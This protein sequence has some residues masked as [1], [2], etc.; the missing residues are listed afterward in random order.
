MVKVEDIF[1]DVQAATLRVNG[2][3]TSENKFVKLGA[4]HTMDLELHRPFTITKL[5]WDII[6]MDRIQLACDVSKRADIAA[7]VLQEGLA[8]VCLVTESMTV[9]KQK[10]EVNVP[11]KRRGTTTDHDK[12]LNRF[13][14]QILQSILTYIDFE[15]VKV[16][17]IASP[18]F[19][20]DGLYKYIMEVAVKT[21]NRT[22]FDHKS[23]IVLAHASSGHKHALGE[24]L[25]DPGIQQQLATTKY[26]QEVQSLA[27][28]YKI[29]GEDPCKAFYGYDY[30][31]KAAEQGAIH[32]LMMTDD[33]FR[34]HDVKERK[35]YIQL[36]E[37]VKSFGGQ[38]L[39]FSS[40]HTSGEQLVQLT[41]IAAILNFPMPDLEEQVELELEKKKHLALGGLAP[42]PEDDLIESD[43]DMD[44]L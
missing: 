12:G 24:I 41:G 34:S 14:D 40:L 42:R 20:K 37:L 35:K 36:V 44:A 25:Q 26:A 6:S 39:I 15:I 21:E 43:H 2:R 22:L 38:A 1:F 4:Y 27:Q 3:N 23:K 30:V 17:I 29:L 7:V 16:L 18:G 28:F 33:L 31:I 5:E 9:V 10:I 13:Y 32:T 8:H 11:R 19:V